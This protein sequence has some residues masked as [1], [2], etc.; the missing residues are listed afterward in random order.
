M[1]YKQSEKFIVCDDDE[2]FNF[3]HCLHAY[4]LKVVHPDKQRL[5]ERMD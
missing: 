3:D 4:I 5:K 2:C 1:L